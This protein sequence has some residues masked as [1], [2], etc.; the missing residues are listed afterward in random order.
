MILYYRGGSQSVRGKNA[1][2]ATYLSGCSEHN[3]GFGQSP[4]EGFGDSSPTRKTAEV[5]FTT[6]QGAAVLRNVDTF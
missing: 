1:K 2:I 6:G 5:P 3:N 4:R